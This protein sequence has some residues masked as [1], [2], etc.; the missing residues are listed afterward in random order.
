MNKLSR[1]LAVALMAT[2]IPATIVLAQQASPGD[3]GG[4]E[5]S[6]T[7]RGPSPETLARLE[8][9][10]IAFAKAALKLTPDQ[11]KLWA[12][13]EANIRA[14]FDERRKAREAWIAKREEHRAEKAKGDDEKGEKLALPERIEKRSERMTERASKMNERA[15]KVKQFAETLKPLYATFTE[16]QKAVAGSVLSHFGQDGRGR[17]GSR[18]AMNRGW[19]HGHGEHGDH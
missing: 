18:W 1:A 16:E 14:N 4:T 6:E 15:A 2:T 19:G 11:E 17:G 9:G 7:H 12:P 5:K 8:D 3:Q 13:V 10:R